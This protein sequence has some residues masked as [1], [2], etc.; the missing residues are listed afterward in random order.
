LG[1]SQSLISGSTGDVRVRVDENSDFDYTLLANTPGMKELV[2]ALGVLKNLPPPEYAPGALNDPTATRPVD[3]V[4]PYPSTEKQQN[5]YAVF[6]DLAATIATAVD[7]LEKEE[8]RLSLVEAQTLSIKEQYTYQINA[9]KST[10]ADAEDVDLTE[11]VAKIQ[12]LQIGLEASF[13]VT[14]LISNLTLVN[15]LGR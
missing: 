15:F 8:Y 13:S 9:F 12:Q 3:D 4:P 11:T 1:Y 2:I 5:F 6:N 14:A 10:V 7:K